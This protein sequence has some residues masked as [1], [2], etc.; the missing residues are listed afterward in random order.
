MLEQV[1]AKLPNY[2]SFDFSPYIQAS[3]GLYFLNVRGQ[4]DNGD[5]TDSVGNAVNSAA[6]DNSGDSDVTEE[7]DDKKV[8]E[9][10]DRRFIL[11][12][13]LGLSVKKNSDSSWDVFVQSVAAGGPVSR[14]AVQVLGVNGE[15][16]AEALTDTEGHASLPNLTAMQNEKRPVAFV[17][18]KG[19][20]LSFLPFGREDRQLNYAK[21][22]VDGNLPS[23]GMQAYLFNDRGIYR[24]GET[25]HVGMIIKAR[26]WAKNVAGLPLVFE[27]TNPRGQVVSKQNLLLNAE[28]LMSADFTVSERAQTGVYNAALYLERGN[29]DKGSVLGTNALR[30][31][32][33]MPDRMKMTSAVLQNDH[34][35]DGLAWLKPEQ[36]SV[37]IA[38]MHLY[39]EPAVNRRVT[40]KLNVAPGA[41]GFQSF[42][43]YSFS[44]DNKV[45]QAFEKTSVKPL[46]M[47]KV[48]HGLN[49]ISLSMANRPFG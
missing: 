6:P 16:V 46:L 20:D 47:Q 42:K 33:F 12:T 24:P 35:V 4:V 31:E 14:V 44:A 5:V 3:R 36:L 11:I 40:G 43:D 1:D 39:G 2:S 34:S 18:R 21:F 48:M 28:G 26:D 45:S 8:A 30:V 37:S 25:A 22:E 49:W 29:Q 15:V 9:V 32:E 23:E 7:G 10:Q 17:A 41:F 38:L 13:D 19:S 27:I